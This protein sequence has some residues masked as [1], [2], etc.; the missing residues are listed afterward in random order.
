MNIFGLNCLSAFLIEQVG[1]GAP[2]RRHLTCD[3]PLP[4][5][6]CKTIKFKACSDKPC[7]WGEYK[8]NQANKTRTTA[9]K[10]LFNLNYLQTTFMYFSLFFSHTCERVRAQTHAVLPHQ[11][12]I[13]PKN[14]KCSWI[15]STLI[16][17]SKQQVSC[18]CLFLQISYMSWGSIFVLLCVVFTVFNLGNLSREHH[19]NIHHLFLLILQ[20]MSCLTGS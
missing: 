7:K 9:N 17:F 5:P 8:Q 20:K 11:H 15:S 2:S 16:L 4:L 10:R 14:T 12:I 19:L 1:C 6:P 3:D 18:V 13:P